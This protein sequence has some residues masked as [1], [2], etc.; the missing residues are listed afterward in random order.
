MVCTCCFSFI[1]PSADDGL[2]ATFF[3]V[4]YL[5]FSVKFEADAET[6]GTMPCLNEAAVAV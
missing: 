4:N 1:T 2:D 6:P 5:I 3:S